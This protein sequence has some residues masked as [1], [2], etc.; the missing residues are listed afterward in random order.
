MS[1]NFF[2]CSAT[3]Q[4]STRWLDAFPA[5]VCRELDTLLAAARPFDVIWV[6]TAHAG[7]GTLVMNLS[8]RLPECPLIVISM[9]PDGEEALAAL[10]H[11][12]RGYC[13][14]M[15]VPMMLRDVELVVRHG[16]L[17]VG[18]ELMTRVIGAAIRTLA[19]PSDASASA[20]S[21]R[22]MEVARKVAAGLSNKEVAARLGITERTVKAHLGAIFEKLGVRDRL[23]LVLRLSTQRDVSLPVQ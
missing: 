1:Q 20:L 22:E 4:P 21:A 3:V 8:R 23:Q 11:G 10:D 5:G 19:A 12:A 13:H 14:A 16:G 9:T 6:D 18:P 7:W 2:L 15:S 17:W